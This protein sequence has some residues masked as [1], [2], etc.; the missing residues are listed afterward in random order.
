MGRCK[1]LAKLLGSLLGSIRLLDIGRELDIGGVEQEDPEEEPC[2][3]E[4]DRIIRCLTLHLLQLNREVHW[5][6][7]FF[8]MKLRGE[9]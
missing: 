9:H 5:T 3:G 1:R 2:L 7:S 4:E 6:N 8:E